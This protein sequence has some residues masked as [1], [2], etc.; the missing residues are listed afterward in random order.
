MSLAGVARTAVLA[1][2]TT[3]YV[4]LVDPHVP[5]RYPTCPW[6][7]VTGLWCPG[8]G[9]LRA[10]H[11]LAHGQL[12]PAVG[13]NALAVLL[14]PVLVVGLVTGRDRPRRRRLLLLVGAALAVA[15]TV[16]RNLPAG[17]ALA[18]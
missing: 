10:A 14:L 4:A 1:A 12:A 18:P 9:G 13:E 7:A 2:A 6:H 5:G 3:T 8:C 17:S 15:F 11:D 16:L